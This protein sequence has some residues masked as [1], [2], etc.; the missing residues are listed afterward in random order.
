PE[1]LYLRNLEATVAAL[2][3]I[4]ER[5]REMGCTFGTFGE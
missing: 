3:V 4:I 2:P 5:L 1:Y